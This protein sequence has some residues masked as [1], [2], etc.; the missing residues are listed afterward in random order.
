MPFKEKTSTTCDNT[1]PDNT[2]RE[3]TSAQ[4]YYTGIEKIENISTIW[5]R[6]SLYTAWFS[7][8]LLAIA[9]SFDAQTLT[10]FQTYAASSFS[11]NTLLGTMST[12]QSIV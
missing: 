6:K 5:D 7:T 1:P 4:D 11:S 2:T 10:S 8:F 9:I 3:D 12:V